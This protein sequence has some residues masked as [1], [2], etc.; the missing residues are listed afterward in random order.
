MAR[1]PS[2]DA[3]DE[4]FDPPV[5]LE[6]GLGVFATVAQSLTLRTDPNPLRFHAGALERFLNGLHPPVAG[7]RA[8]P[9]RAARIRMAL[10]PALGVGL[11][12]HERADV[13]DLGFFRARNVR[14]VEIEQDVPERD[15]LRRS[16]GSAR[17]ARWSGRSG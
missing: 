3:A 13:V 8:G 4:D 5:L 1:L 16:A 10:E 6:T 11:L 14:L 17:S 9:V 2:L 12:L 15:P 7:L